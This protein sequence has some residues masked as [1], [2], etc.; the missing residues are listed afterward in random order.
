MSSIKVS[1]VIPTF[2]RAGHILS[3]LNAF[4]KQSYNREF[5]EVIV[6]NDGSTDGTEKILKSFKSKTPINFDFISQPNRGVS[7]ARNLGIKHSRGDYIAFTD[8]DCIVPDDWVERLVSSI[9]SSE[10]NIAGVGGPLDNVTFSDNLFISRFIKYLDEFNYI[11]VMGRFI[12]K[13]VHVTKL[14]GTETIAYLRTSNAVFKKRCLLEIGG[15]DEEFKKPGGEDPD[16]C[17]RLLNLGYR[18][19]F[20]RNIMVLHK[21]RESWKSY[22]NSLRN[23]LCGER[24]KS[25]K[26]YLYKNRSIRNTYSFIPVQKIISTIICCLSYPV[27]VLALFNKK[28]FKLYDKLL[29]PLILIITKLYAF[30]V[31]C[32]LY[33]RYTTRNSC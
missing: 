32:I 13:P 23:Y 31:S 17:Y 11:P 19:I 27:N 21:S 16:L 1:V 29:F 6:V 9:E 28:Q 8:D 3:C 7:A 10:Y 33:I 18:F 24:K 22:F 25:V 15:F 20:D 30:I 4:E 12:V 5:F 26:K 14:N 2:N